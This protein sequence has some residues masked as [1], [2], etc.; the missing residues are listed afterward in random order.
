MKILQTKIFLFFICFL[1]AWF[2]VSITLGLQEQ[3][4]QFS[5]AKQNIAAQNKPDTVNDYQK[6]LQANLFHGLVYAPHHQQIAQENKEIAN[7]DSIPVSSLPLVLTGT[8]I[9]NNV[10]ENKAVI[11]NGKEQK[12]YAVNQTINDWKIME[13]NREEVIISQNSKKEKLVLRDENAVKQADLT[14]SLSKTELLTLVSNVSNL[15]Q[16][17]QLIP[18]HKD[19]IQ[20]LQIINIVSGTY[21]DKFNLMPQDIIMQV[22]D[23]KISSYN[24]I[25]QLSTL[26]QQKEFTMTLFRNN[27]KLMIKYTLT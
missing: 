2:A 9:L 6:I 17:I 16:T 1:S 3:S 15:L 22:N 14:Y 7:T 12:I 25:A 10:S 27:K 23:R 19:N 13:I 8:I 20:G 21:F 4:F 24:D 5:A 11:G 26:A 18:Y